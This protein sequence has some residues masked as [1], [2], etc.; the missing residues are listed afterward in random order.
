MAMELVS[1][2]LIAIAQCKLYLYC[3]NFSHFDI[4]RQVEFLFVCDQPARLFEGIRS[5][6]ETRSK[7]LQLLALVIESRFDSIPNDGACSSDAH[8]VACI[9]TA[10][11]YEGCFDGRIVTNE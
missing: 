8:K 6:S 1:F 7:Y 9:W 11:P 2:H 3:W 5:E 10:F 4:L